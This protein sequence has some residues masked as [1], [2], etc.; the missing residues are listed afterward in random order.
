[1]KY[2]FSF[3]FLLILQTQF[4]KLC[5]QNKREII[6][7]QQCA[8]MDNLEAAFSKNPAL[9]L[10][11]TQKL[12]TFNNMMVQKKLQQQKGERAAGT[13]GVTY[14]IPIVFHIVLKDPSV[15]TD[16][17]ILSQLNTLNKDFAGTNPDG[18]NIPSYFKSLHGQSNIQFCLA[19]RTPT[20]D[21]T[22]GIERTI[23]TKD[24]FLATDNGVK[25]NSTGGVDLWDES[26]YYNVW[27]CVLG[28]SILGYAT[29]PTDGETTEQG[30]AIH[31]QSLPGG[32]YTNYNGG[33]TLTHETGHYFNLY[34]IW[35]DDNGACTG[36]D[37]IDDTPNQA[38]Y[39]TGCY[40]G[41]H[42]DACTPTGNGVL[43]EDY[44]DY[45]N[46]QCLLLFT[47]EQDDRMQTALL[48][49]RPS[50]LSSNACTP[51]VKY[52]VDAQ[53]KAILAPPTRIC[54]NSFSPIVTIRNR[55]SNTLTTVVV[56]V[57]VD[58]GAPVNINYTGSLVS[59]DMA[60][61]SFAPLTLSPGIHNLKFYV[62]NPNNSTDQDNSNDTLKST[63]QYYVP[64]KN[65]SEGF[66][67]NSFPPTAWDI[68][69]PDNFIT[70]KKTLAAAKSGTASVMIDNFNYTSLGQ[71]DYLRLPE[72]NLAGVD[73][74]FF[75]FQVAAATFTPITTVNNNFDTLEV[76]MSKDCGLTYTTLYKK[77]GATLVTQTDPATTFFIP[78][79]NQWR[80]DSINLTP[81]IN[82][83]SFILCFRNTTG[84][85]NTIYLDDVNLR[86]IT[87]NPNLKAKGF[88]VT[89]NPATN[90]IQ[91]QF[92][93]NPANLRGIS[94]YNLMGQKLSEIIVSDSPGQTLYN[95]NISQYPI[96]MY[97][98]RAVFS[99]KVLIRK[100]IKN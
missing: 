19:Q 31:Y 17:Q 45:S 25:H 58:N 63:V 18:V 53:I 2:F 8:T 7:Q 57:M 40:S 62:S 94:L 47:P 34:H 56:S 70:W 67:G 23:T 54:S 30:V 98:I 21:V 55:G 82:N 84:N 29:F 42:T 14:T 74:A 4:I 13:V 85:E 76:L 5:A 39:T 24:Q 32:T 15:V 51:P 11:Y 49:Y 60:N 96:G 90:N 97:L 22:T 87:I 93:P 20:G 6:Q 61:I 27:V 75:T 71:Q 28:N 65:I 44:M 41:I 38:N 48:T 77:G 12:E 79:A 52:A 46:D 37:Y 1:M 91:V 50:L 64:V 88:L 10:R 9:K 3:L 72:A 99:D 83:G 95:F 36:T 73:S 86:T 78:T 68:V 16:A 59:L 80:K 100:I 69:N 66:E 26:K 35:G 43:Y 33:K 92:Y 89:P 81:Y